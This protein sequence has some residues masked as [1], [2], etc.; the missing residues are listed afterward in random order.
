[1]LRDRRDALVVD[2]LLEDV[3]RPGVGQPD[4]S[5]AEP[6]LGHA[7]VD[8]DAGGVERHA[9]VADAG[10]GRHAG[11]VGD[12]EDLGGR[13]V[14]AGA[15]RPDPDADRHGC[16]GD[17]LEQVLDLVVGDDRAPAVDL[18]DQGLRPLVV[19]VAR[20]PISTSASRIGSNSPLTCSTSTRATST[21]VSSSVVDRA[22]GRR[23]CRS[24]WAARSIA[25]RGIGR[26]AR[27]PAEPTQVMPARVASMPIASLRKGAS[28][29]RDL[30]AIVDRRTSRRGGG[31]G[32]CGEDH[33]NGCD[34]P[35]GIPIRAAVCSSSNS[36]ASRRS[37]S[38]CP[39]LEVLAIAAP[40]ALDEYLR[41][42][43]FGR[44]ATRLSKTGVIDV[45]GTA[46]PGIDDIV[47]LGKIKQLE[48]SGDY[49]LIVVD[50]PAAG[51]AITF[52]TAASGLADSVRSGPIRTQADEVLE[53]LHDPAAV[54]GRAGVAPRGDA[55]Q[56][57]DRDRLRAR[58]PGRRAARP[59]DPQRGRRLE[60]PLPD[61]DETAAA[62]RRCSTRR[63]RRAAGR[64]GRL[65]SEPH[66]HAGR[67]APPAR[68]RA[69]RC[70]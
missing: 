32:G 64:G 52:L 11:H 2:A 51:H 43:G 10:A 5:V 27:T 14:E 66:R 55:G 58:G 47:V 48:R 1:M 6:L 28:G 45:V 70:R 56:R 53:M 24:W 61:R 13:A 17:E 67:R 33:G 46:A 39:D 22:V 68:R 12:G 59:G 23:P 29:E 30:A 16:V 4:R 63:R 57:A 20:S 34:R 60:P 54:P 8:L 21:I 42:H 9:D 41:E 25:V 44:I 7:E 40:D 35:C 36:T 65:P 19:G 49:D 37:P 18:E 15:G 3:E 69:S 62:R 31:Q 26:P 50:G 38:W